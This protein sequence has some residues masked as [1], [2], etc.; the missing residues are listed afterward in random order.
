MLLFLTITISFSQDKNFDSYL[1]EIQNEF[2]VPQISADSLK[3]IS[4][5]I[6]DTREKEEFEIS[7]IKNAINVGYNDFSLDPLN[8]IEKDTT[9]I[10]Y[11]SVGYRSSKIAQ[12]L[13]DAGFKDV[14]N[15]NGGIFKWVNQ[16]NEIVNHSVKTDSLHTYNKRWGRYVSN[17]NIVKV[18]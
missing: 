10:V 1:I 2:Q 12:I 7:H 3:N 5:V 13:I 16:N 18:P 8:A 4:S 17:K 15:L 9:I 14:R 6:L 11:C